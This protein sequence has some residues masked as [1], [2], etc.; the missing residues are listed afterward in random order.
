MVLVISAVLPVASGAGARVIGALAAA[1]TLLITFA[2]ALGAAPRVRSLCMLAVTSALAAIFL[3]RDPYHLVILQA[4]VVVA[5]I[6]NS[7][8]SA[9][10]KTAAS[11]G[12]SPV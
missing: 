6:V 8:Y 3:V 9:L 7:T 12:Q 5:L 2:F 11:R 10:R 4:L 1:A